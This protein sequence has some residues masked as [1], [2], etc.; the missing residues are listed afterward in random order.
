MKKYLDIFLN[1]VYGCIIGVANIIPGVSGGT[2]AVMLNIYDKLIDSFTGIRKHFGKSMKFLVPILIGAGI[3]IVV[4]S[5]LIKY[6]IAEQPLPT[7]FFFIGLILGS[8]PLVFKKSLETKFRPVSI[9]PLVIFLGC[10]IA[11]AFV[12]TSGTEASDAGI[13]LDV[14]SWFWLFFGSAFAAMCMI[15]PGVS[16]SMILMI[17]GLY[18][19]VLGAI[20]DLT[21]NFMNSCMILLPVGLGVLLGIVAGAKL[22]DIC[23]KRFPQMSYFA[24]IGLML[25]SPLIIYLKFQSESPD[26]FRLDTMNIIAS[27]IVFAIGL[28]IALVFGSEKLKEKFEKKNGTEKT[29]A[30]K[31]AKE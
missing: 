5:K 10:M 21:K 6:L 28:G 9:I 17:L 4:F 27:A 23:I 26:N 7:C 25:G 2:M 12:Q 30:V 8:L 22:I 15:I 1:A 18:S 11:L 29:E 19:T 24:I 16:G 13:K 14:L 31:S 20:S 3:G